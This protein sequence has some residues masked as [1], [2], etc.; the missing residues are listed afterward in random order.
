MTISI[1]SKPK[2]DFNQW[3]QQEPDDLKDDNLFTLE[4]LYLR[5]GKFPFRAVKRVSVFTNRSGVKHNIPIG[6]S[7][8]LEGIDYSGFYYLSSD[9]IS[10]RT[11]KDIRQWQFGEI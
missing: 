3:T 11:F 10:G 7:I 2:L 8:T 1:K 6:R 5:H 9:L 4:E